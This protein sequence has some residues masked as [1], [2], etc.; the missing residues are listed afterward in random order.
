MMWCIFFKYRATLTSFVNYQK[1]HQITP[2]MSSCIKSINLLMN[3]SFSKLFDFL[4]THTC[5]TCMT[6]LIVSRPLKTVRQQMS[7]QNFQFSIHCQKLS[8]QK[9]T[10]YNMLRYLK[11][12]IC[13]ISSFSSLFVFLI[14]D[15]FLCSSIDI[16]SF[17]SKYSDNC[18]S[19]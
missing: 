6:Q 9:I 14:S 1:L 12:C 13:S 3:K 8:C 17:G 2:R 5:I 18:M 11:L 10:V 16:S 19:G 4:H 7:L 15:M